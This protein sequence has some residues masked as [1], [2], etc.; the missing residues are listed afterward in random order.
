MSQLKSL[1]ESEQIPEEK[2]KDLANLFISNPMAVMTEVQEMNLS[3]DFIQKAMAIVMSN[4]E[5]VIQFA[6]SLGLSE[7]VIAEAKSRV[8][9]MMPGS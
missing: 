5:E 2:I 8:Q 3:P 9:G 6:E 7:E 1:F 4:P